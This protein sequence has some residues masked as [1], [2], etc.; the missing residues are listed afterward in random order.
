MVWA[1]ALGDANEPGDG[2]EG[3]VVQVVCSQSLRAHAVELDTAHADLHLQVLESLLQGCVE[4]RLCLL[5]LLARNV[6]DGLGVVEEKEINA[7]ASAGH[8]PRDLRLESTL[9]DFVAG[10]PLRLRL[11]L[12]G[13]LLHI[14]HV[15][16][17]ETCHGNQNELLSSKLS[18]HLSICRGLGLVGIPQQQRLHHAGRNQLALRLNCCSVE[19]VE[20]RVDALGQR[21]VMV[22]LLAGEPH[23]GLRQRRHRPARA[24]VLPGRVLQLCTLPHGLP[25]FPSLRQLLPRPLHG[26]LWH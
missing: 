14:R 12:L 7:G 1:H 18:L 23:A 13:M 6:E 4:R 19:Q 9:R 21:L 15:R 26:C 2:E 22:E 25:H 16:R 24:L 17:D 10:D 5:A 8:D 20:A 11:T 3:R